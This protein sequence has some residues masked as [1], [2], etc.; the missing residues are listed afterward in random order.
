LFTGTPNLLEILLA[1][2][3]ISSVWLGLSYSS[4]HKHASHQLHGRNVLAING[5]MLLRTQQVASMYL[6]TGVDA[7]HAKQRC[8]SSSEFESEHWSK[9]SNQE[10]RQTGSS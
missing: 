9:G 7:W 6:D 10:P 3:P 4:M 8:S 1:I 2:V 5:H